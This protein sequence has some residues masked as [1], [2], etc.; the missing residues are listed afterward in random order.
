MKDI[1]PNAEKKTVIIGVVCIAVVLA[2]TVF[3]II[4]FALSG[5]DGAGEGADT[6]AAETVPYVN[7]FDTSLTGN[8]DTDPE[9]RDGA[10]GIGSP[11]D[12]SQLTAESGSSHGIDVSRWQG[13]I[14]WQ[15]VAATGVEFAYIRIGY[16]GENGTIYKDDNA[17]YNIQQAEKAGLLIGVYFFTNAV[18]ET[19]AA[20]EARWTV[21]AIAGYPVS[22]PVVYDCEGFGVSSSRMYLVSREQRTQN[23]ETFL[24]TVTEAGYEAMLYS[25]AA[26]LSDDTGWDISRIEKTYKIWV[27]QYPA[28][29]YPAVKNPDYK[30][31]CSAWQYT[32]RGRVDGIEGNVDM[33][34]CYFDR[35]AAAPKA[36][37]RRP[38][39]VSAPCD[40]GEYSQVSETVTAKELTNLR[41]APTTKSNVVMQLK[42]GDRITRTGI[43]TN[44]WSRL[45]LN[46]TTLYAITSYLTTD[47]SYSTDV[48]VDQ[49]VVLGQT[50]APRDDSVTAK[51]LVNLRAQPTTDSEIIGTLKN[52]DFLKR[53]AVSDKGWSR[54][55]YNGRQVY[56]VTSYLTTELSTDTLSP[57]TEPTYSG[58][59][60]VFENVTA[61]I[62]TNLRDAPT[63]SGSNV[64]YTLKNGEYVKRTGIHSN[65]WSRLEYNG[66][67]VYAVSSYLI[68]EGEETAEAETAEAT[69]P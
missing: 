20:E 57:E 45:E 51:E 63:T 2:L 31:M 50:F 17:D 68:T 59:T 64:V 28:V 24:K 36:P 33:V 25:G 49:D 22:Y 14:D 1:F 66:Q 3:F 43:G 40:E 54:L 56:A 11:V 5:R 60:D 53:V 42:N 18:N 67:T 52:G 27:A 34:L 48:P 7:E 35:E 15:A 32:N 37:E 12:F 58:F 16:R 46:G 39:D 61:K 65:G 62:E 30:G 8:G 41:D 13:R 69:E 6:T 38:A 10:E 4:F 9:N 47:L 44:G 19:E 21:E 55:E 23:A 26:E 29:T